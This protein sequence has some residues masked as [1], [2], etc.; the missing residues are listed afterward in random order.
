MNTANIAAIGIA[1]VVIIMLLLPVLFRFYMAYADWL[2]ELLDELKI[3]K[4]E[5]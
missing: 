3:G 4:N 5:H 2:W 1:V